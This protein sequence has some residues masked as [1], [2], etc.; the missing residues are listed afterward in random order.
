MY[1]KYLPAFKT[2]YTVNIYAGLTAFENLW[3]QIT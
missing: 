3:Y 1:R 2:A